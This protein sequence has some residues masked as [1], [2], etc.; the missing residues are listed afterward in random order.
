MKFKIW[1]FGLLVV[2]VLV[3]AQGHIPFED[4]CELSISDESMVEELVDMGILEGDHE[5]NI[6]PYDLVNR[7]EA[8]KLL[9]MMSGL[10]SFEPSDDGISPFSDVKPDDWFYPYI[11]NAYEKGYIS[12]YPDGTFR[13]SG[14]INRAELLKLLVE[15]ELG[16]VDLSQDYSFEDVSSTD[17][18]YEYV[19][20]LF[21]HYEDKGLESFQDLD[22]EKNGLLK[23]GKYV[24]RI[25]ILRL[26]WGLNVFSSGMATEPDPVLDKT[27]RFISLSDE[28]I[29]YQK[30][31]NEIR[32]INLWIPEAN[33]NIRW[34][35]SL[36][37][38]TFRYDPSFSPQDLNDIKLKIS[39]RGGNNRK[40]LKDQVFN[41]KFLAQNEGLLKFE[42]PQPIKLYGYYDIHVELIGNLRDGAKDFS[43]EAGTFWLEKDDV[44]FNQKAYFEGQFPIKS[45]SVNITEDSRKIREAYG[46]HK[47]KLQKELDEMILAYDKK[48]KKEDDEKLGSERK[49]ITDLLLKAIDFGLNPDIC[50]EKANKDGGCTTILLKVVGDWEYYFDNYIYFVTKL[51]SLGANIYK[52]NKEGLDLN[53]LEYG[54]FYSS[55]GYHIKDMFEKRDNPPVKIDVGA[56]LEK[57]EI[58]NYR[59]NY[60]KGPTRYK[61]EGGRIIGYNLTRI[62]PVTRNFDIS[63]DKKEISVLFTKNGGDII[64]RP[65]VKKGKKL[66]VVLEKTSEGEYRSYNDIDITFNEP[67]LRDY[68]EVVYLEGGS[69]ES[70]YVGDFVENPEIGNVHRERRS[71]EQLFSSDMRTQSRNEIV[72]YKVVP[73]TGDVSTD[74]EVKFKEEGKT[75]VISGG[76]ALCKEL[77]LFPLRQDEQFADL[78]FARTTE[79]C[80]PVERVEVTFE[81]KLHGG[82]NVFLLDDR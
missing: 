33:Q 80:T 78:I 66:L 54:D 31:N 73:L 23:P 5:G 63:T 39:Y 64:V 70:L 21:G 55:M 27:I 62:Y 50:L 4:A 76:D 6:R 22:L 7:A 42:F 74:F 75:V 28:I 49:E 53:D 52:K 26:Y 67:I 40:C 61:E 14:G 11:K 59:E 56:E 60:H 82:L 68:L 79:Q 65:A 12:G 17:W 71:L 38:L 81:E 43:M 15:L 35:Y 45:P 72:G 20:V 32:F 13:P 9:L 25:D 8:L 18:F 2:P 3:H 37:G 51:E 41:G 47:K 77:S 57:I 36:E 29:H 69:L 10:D 19:S 16:Q 30:P 24:R 34:D 46:R 44:T 48:S 1:L 58:I